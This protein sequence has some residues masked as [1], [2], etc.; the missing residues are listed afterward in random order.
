MQYSR[1]FY[2]YTPPRPAAE[3]AVELHELE[4]RLGE[5]LAALFGD[6]D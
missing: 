4:L 6:E 2:E 3:L 5:S 1:Y